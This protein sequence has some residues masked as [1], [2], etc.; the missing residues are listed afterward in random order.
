MKKGITIACENI[1]ILKI[2]EIDGKLGQL[3]CQSFLFGKSA[4]MIVLM[5][6][7]MFSQSIHK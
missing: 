4:V 6:L 2:R 3:Y 1:D 5:F 7:E